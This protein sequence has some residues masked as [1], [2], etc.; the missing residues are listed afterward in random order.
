MVP[1][2]TDTSDPKGA[3]SLHVHPL[4]LKKAQ[5]LKV[6]STSPNVKTQEPAESTFKECHSNKAELLPPKLHDTCH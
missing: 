6:W 2:W 5:R 1:L 4:I 3:P